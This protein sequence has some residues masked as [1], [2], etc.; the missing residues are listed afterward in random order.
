[1]RVGQGSSATP[2]AL[3]VF[4]ALAFFTLSTGKNQTWVVQNALLHALSASGMIGG[5]GVCGYAQEHDKNG[6]RP[7]QRERRKQMTSLQRAYI[8]RSVHITHETASEAMVKRQCR[9]LDARQK[10]QPTYVP[11]WPGL[12]SCSGSPRAA[13]WRQQTH[14]DL[15]CMSPRLC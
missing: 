14:H 8:S 12:S 1:M 2:A 9:C 15:V 5:S 10:Q 3:A 7:L 13:M 4:A 6:D 11:N